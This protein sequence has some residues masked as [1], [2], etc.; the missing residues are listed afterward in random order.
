MGEGPET[1]RSRVWAAEDVKGNVDQVDLHFIIF[2]FLLFTHSPIP[3]YADFIS[4]LY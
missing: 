1:H 2:I 4:R 3:N